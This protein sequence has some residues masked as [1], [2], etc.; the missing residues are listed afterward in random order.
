MWVG[1][2]VG[3]GVGGCECPGEVGK[4]DMFSAVMIRIMDL[5]IFN[6]YACLLSTI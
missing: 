6:L 1:V 5:F 4:S 2:G 3:V